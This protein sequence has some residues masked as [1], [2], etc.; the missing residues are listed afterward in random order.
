MEKPLVSVLIPAIGNYINL[1]LA[2]T[3][4]LLQTYTNIEIIIRDP[5]P[6]DTIQNLLEKDFLPYSTKITYIRDSKCMSKLNILQ[7]LLRISNGTYINFLMED[8]LFYPTK[9]ERMMDYFLKDATNSIKLV[10]SYTDSIDIHGDLIA[11]RTDIK[12]KYEM[13]MQWDTITSSNFILQ[14]NDY[15]GGLSVPLF[16]KQ[17]LILPIGYFS[18]HPFLKEI[19]MASWLTLISQGSLVLIGEELIFERKNQD[20]QKAKIE[21]DLVTDWIN[22]IKLTN[23]N[24]TIINRDTEK[25][26]IQKILGWINHLFLKKQSMLTMIERETI[27]SYREYLY[28]LQMID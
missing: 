22:L 28:R 2:L 9:I 19:A 18:G 3:S 4:V 12:K 1:E 11:P 21:L 8:D 5:S 15:V 24:G 6:T 25:G 14:N 13:D 7:E 23:Q 27:Q 26:L 17:D 20:P 10:T 16:R